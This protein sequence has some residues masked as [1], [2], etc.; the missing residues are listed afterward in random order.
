MLVRVAD[1]L[2]LCWFSPNADFSVRLVAIFIGVNQKP[3]AV[4]GVDS[5]V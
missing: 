2:E 3:A 1:L 4:L 5:S